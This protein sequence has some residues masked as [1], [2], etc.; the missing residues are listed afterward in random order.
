MNRFSISNDILTLVSI[1]RDHCQGHPCSQN[2]TRSGN[3]YV[4]LAGL[5]N[6]LEY[7][8]RISLSRYDSLY[9]HHNTDLGFPCPVS[10]CMFLH[11]VL[12]ARLPCLPR[13][14]FTSCPN[15]PHSKKST[16][17]KFI[18]DR[19][20]IVIVNNNNDTCQGVFHSS[21]WHIV[22]VSDGDVMTMCLVTRPVPHIN[23]P[24]AFGICRLF[25]KQY[26]FQHYL[27]ES[28][29]IVVHPN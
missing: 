16:Q 13:S 9:I 14:H 7:S 3:I 26:L 28:V 23:M 5:G 24:P 25:L 18:F 11:F 27:A 8:L 19:V 2:G 29:S 4:V 20:V 6:P 15:S 1:S 10:I 17:K 21:V 22:D 12:F